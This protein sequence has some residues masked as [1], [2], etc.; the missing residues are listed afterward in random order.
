MK[1]RDC[2][3]RMFSNWWKTISAWQ[4]AFRFSVKERCLENFRKALK[5]KLKGNGGKPLHGH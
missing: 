3:R 5:K 2:L 4:T 1:R